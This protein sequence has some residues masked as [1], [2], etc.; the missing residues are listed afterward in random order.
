MLVCARCQLNVISFVD[1]PLSHYWYDWQ[2]A[3]E[4]EN[5]WW[6]DGWMDGWMDFVNGWMDCLMDR[7]MGIYPAI[8]RCFF[9]E[10]FSF[11]L[12]NV[13]FIWYKK[14]LIFQY[15]L[16]IPCYL[17]FFFTKVEKVLHVLQ[18]LLNSYKNS[19]FFPWI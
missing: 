19:V 17:L 5:T 8:F 15:K 11:I 18:Y 7:L 13:C 6:M 12:D 14:I 16:S 10:K 1:H 3:H 2:V 4:M 9:L